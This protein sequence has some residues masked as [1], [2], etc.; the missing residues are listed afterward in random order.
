MSGCVRSSL[1]PVFASYLY[2]VD[3]AA[4]AETGTDHLYGQIIGS[5]L[6]IFPVAAA[7]RT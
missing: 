2:K 3:M 6:R 5:L 7:G 4:G 1:R